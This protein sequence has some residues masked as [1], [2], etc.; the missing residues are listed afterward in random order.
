[1]ACIIPCGS[2]M[3]WMQSNVVTRSTEW[4]VGQRLVTRV[5]ERGVGQPGL[6]Q[7]LVGPA[8]GVLGDVVAGDRAGRERLGEQQHGAAGAA[9]DVGDPAA[10]RAAS[11]ATPS[12]VG[13]TV[14][15][16]WARFHGSKLRSM[17]TAPSGPWLS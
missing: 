2:V 14:G 16:R 13:S 12:S 4:S 7:A 6:G 11:A 1:M 15:S 5:V 8:E 17:P 3:S 9:A 10:G